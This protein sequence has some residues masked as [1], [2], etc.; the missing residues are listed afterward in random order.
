ML[1]LISGLLLPEPA[2]LLDK[3]VKY[4]LQLVTSCRTLCDL[5]TDLSNLTLPVGYS[6]FLFL[7]LIIEVLIVARVGIDNSLLIS[8]LLLQVLYYL[9]VP[10][11]LLLV[12]VLHLHSLVHSL[13][14]GNLKFLQFLPLLDIELLSLSEFC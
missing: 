13:S 2:V 12:S 6:R 14:E 3:L 9:Q 11:L 4:A 8:Q 1:I 10:L 5:L 7:N